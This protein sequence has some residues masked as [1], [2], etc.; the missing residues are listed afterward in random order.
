M[1]LIV[2]TEAQKVTSRICWQVT[3][4][5]AIETALVTSWAVSDVVVLPVVPTAVENVLQ[6]RL[7]MNCGS[8]DSEA[9]AEDG[10][11]S[12]GGVDRAP[13]NVLVQYSIDE[14]RQWHM[15]HTLCLPPTCGPSHSALQSSW[16]SDE[17][18][19][20]ERLTLPLPYAALGEPL[21]VRFMQKGRPGL[22]KH[23]WAIDDVHLTACVNGCTGHGTCV[24]DNRC[25]CDAG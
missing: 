15:M 24:G 19:P 11:T 10:S 12:D 16:S 14:G 20:W 25:L 21:R 1:S 7:Q 17:T 13:F 2:P 9:N 4:E 3:S 5:S 6:F 8:G 23:S 18:A 22:Q